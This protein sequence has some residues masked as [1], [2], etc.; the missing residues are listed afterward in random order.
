MINPIDKVQ[1]KID[2]I[3]YA[4]SKHT[5]G[6]HIRKTYGG[7][8]EKVFDYID[9][10][11]YKHDDGKLFFCTDTLEY[12]DIFKRK[13]GD[14]IVMF[15]QSYKDRSVEGMREALVDFCLLSKCDLIVGTKGSSFSDMSWMLSPHST[16]G[17]FV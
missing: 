8:P 17:I 13:Y 3:L 14:K 1:N 10:Y 2:H 4:F 6:V 15:E 5:I 12:N 9:N 11:L 16:K 7:H